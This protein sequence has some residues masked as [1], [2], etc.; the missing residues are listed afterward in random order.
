MTRM[1]GTKVEVK[2]VTMSYENVAAAIA[3][4]LYATRTIPESWEVTFLDLGL[5]IN[6]D[7]FVEF[8]I[9][10]TKPVAR[11]KLKLVDEN[12]VEQDNDPHQEILPFEVFE[13]IHV[14]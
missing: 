4:F 2:T 7:G 12:F 11:P 8:D 6:D 10:V 5:P 1:T 3:S 14:E 13:K 9:E